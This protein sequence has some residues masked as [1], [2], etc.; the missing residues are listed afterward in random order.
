[1][2]LPAVSRHAGS[3]RSEVA[4]MLWM[5]CAAML[6]GYCAAACLM[7]LGAADLT[8]RRWQR[9][10]GELIGGLVGFGA[11]VLVM[12]GAAAVLSSTAENAEER[13]RLTGSIVSSEITW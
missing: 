3:E 7:V 8:A 10:T 4:G 6:T 9:A 2:M 11:G 12:G 13:A 5:M 1:M